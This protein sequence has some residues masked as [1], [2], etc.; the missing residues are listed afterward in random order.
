ME[1]NIDIYRL[2]NDLRNYFG[3]AAMYNEMAYVNLIKVD[4]SKR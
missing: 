2:R 1:I 3:V 4:T